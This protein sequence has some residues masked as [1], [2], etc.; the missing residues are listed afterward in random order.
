MEFLLGLICIVLGIAIII[1]PDAFLRFEDHFRIKGERSYSDLAI[2][3]MRFRGVI[4]IIV[5]IILIVISF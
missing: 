1:N 4:A 5:G 3:F 2:F